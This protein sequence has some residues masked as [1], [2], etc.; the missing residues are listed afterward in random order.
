MVRIQFMK[1]LRTIKTIVQLPHLFILT[2]CVLISSCNYGI[3]D[4]DK[5]NKSI[6]EVNFGDKIYS[7]D[8]KEFQITHNVDTSNLRSGYFV[9]KA[10]HYKDNE[11]KKFP[12]SFSSDDVTIKSFG[13]AGYEC[14]VDLLD[15][16]E[17]G[18]YRIY[19]KSSVDSSMD[20]I[21]VIN[22]VSNLKNVVADYEI[23][24]E[25]KKDGLE[26]TQEMISG[27]ITSYTKNIELVA[28]AVYN[29]YVRDSQTE[30]P[31]S[32]RT[33][34]PQVDGDSIYFRNT[35]T[36]HTEM[37]CLT[38]DKASNYIKIKVGKTDISVG[39]NITLKDISS[40]SIEERSI[41]TESEYVIS[42][43]KNTIENPDK[44]YD[45]NVNINSVSP[46]PQEILYSID[47]EIFDE[48]AF[49]NEDYYKP[50]I[51]PDA[52]WLS[53]TQLIYTY[54]NETKFKIDTDGVLHTFSV[55]PINDTTFDMASKN[56]HCYIYAKYRED[57]EYRWKWRIMVG[58]ILE[59]I[60]LLTYN[61]TDGEKVIE[62][63]LEIKQGDTTG[64]IFRA[65]YIPTTTGS[66]NTLWYIA[67]SKQPQIF[68]DSNSV[69]FRAPQPAA[70]NS[71]SNK[72][73]N[74]MG[75][76]ND[77]KTIGDFTAYYYFEET[78]VNGVSELWT[79]YNAIGENCILVAL[80]TDTY[81]YNCFGINNFMESTV[82]VRG[83]NYTSKEVINAPKSYK[84]TSNNVILTPYNNLEGERTEQS[85]PYTLLDDFPQYRTFYMDVDS[86]LEI[87][88]DSNF[89]M[90]QV[91]ATPGNSDAR[92]VFG[93]IGTDVDI[94][95]YKAII[96]IATKYCREEEEKR[97]EKLRV[98]C[99][100]DETIININVNNGLKITMRI[101]VYDNKDS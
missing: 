52:H 30:E 66:L 61:N 82:V 98:N 85:Y 47:A 10:T 94:N 8:N 99:L 93:E 76:V 62:K 22:L 69:Q 27:T 67:E 53:R 16:T 101:V 79:N 87:T 29:I 42:L 3:F 72:V 91:Y 77:E 39:C 11:A 81:M 7:S 40:A 84:D 73:L 1:N 46:Q 44:C 57:K 26:Y 95:G 74:F 97:T 15:L 17:L 35:N 14:A 18:T 56:L 20:H 60:Q 75:G 31:V 25:Y 100:S 38:H 88:L 83:V 86:T 54:E 64:W 59:G 36:N 78:A 6:L 63:D 92:N 24:E 55:T 28:G 48:E 49:L 21:F 13:Q 4:K 9:F 89:Q 70:K 32:I 23:Q 68:T 19:C 43:K 90:E 2:I 80:N 5:P 45:Y 96:A 50:S 34:Y 71:M 58:G 51:N 33:I 41:T 12:F 37:V 65:K